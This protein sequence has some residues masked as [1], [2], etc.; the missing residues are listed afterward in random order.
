[1][2]ALHKE[3]WVWLKIIDIPKSGSCWY[4]NFEP[5]PHHHGNLLWELSPYLGGKGPTPIQE[6]HFGSP[7]NFKYSKAV[8]PGAKEFKGGFAWM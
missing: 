1:M 7:D 2:H 6:A 5:Q 4:S 8:L 3:T